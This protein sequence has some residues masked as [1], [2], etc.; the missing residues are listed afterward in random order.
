MK[1]QETDNYKGVIVCPYF[2]CIPWKARDQQ[3]TGDV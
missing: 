3:G 1:K 2:Y